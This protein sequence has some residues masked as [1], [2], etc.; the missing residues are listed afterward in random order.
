MFLNL[1]PFPL[2]IDH[3]LESLRRQLEQVFESDSKKHRQAQNWMPKAEL[4]ATP[5]ALILSV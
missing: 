3:Q 2:P 5:D 1:A 4:I